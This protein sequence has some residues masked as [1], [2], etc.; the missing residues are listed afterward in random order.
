M[1][2]SKALAILR[3]L[4]D[5]MKKKQWEQERKEDK[6]MDEWTER[7]MRQDKLRFEIQEAQR[8]GEF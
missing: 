8:D 6:E 3:W 7:E 4:S 1:D 2:S 5:H